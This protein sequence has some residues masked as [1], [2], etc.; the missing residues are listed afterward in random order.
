MSSLARDLNRSLIDRQVIR[1]LQLAVLH[2]VDETLNQLTADQDLKSDW[3]VQGFGMLRLYIRN[4]GRLHVWDQALR[5]PGVSMIHNHSW[6]LHSTVISGTLANTRFD[7]N[8]GRGD[9]YHGKRLVTG[10]QTYDVVDLGKVLLDEN[11]AEF[12]EAGDSYAQVAH[13]VHRTDAYNGTITL[14]LR[15]EYTNGQADV[16]WP[17]GTEW[18]TAKPRKATAQEVY[19][20]LQRA[21]PILEAEVGWKE[22]R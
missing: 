16:Y 14:M 20:V 11:F 4:L 6:D 3:S 17:V 12:Y 5:Y 18:G 2:V 8:N 10:Y 7:V 19:Q 22:P 1:S 13:E 15:Q 21:L 9:L